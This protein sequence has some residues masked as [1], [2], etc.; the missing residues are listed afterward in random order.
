MNMKPAGQRTALQLFLLF[1]ID[2][3]RTKE[4]RQQI[5]TFRLKYIFLADKMI[6][7]QEVR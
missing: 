1:K 3:A 5:K 4:Y 7:R 6:R 2:T